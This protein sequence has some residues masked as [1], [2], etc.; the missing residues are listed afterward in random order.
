MAECNVGI[1]MAD[2]HDQI[3]ALLGKLDRSMLVS[4][5]ID[6]LKPELS[7]GSALLVEFAE[8]TGE[9]HGGYFDPSDHPELEEK[10]TAF[11]LK[12]TSELI[13]DEIENLAFDLEL[14]GDRVIAWRSIAHSPDWPQERMRDGH[15][16]ICWT[17]NEAH[18]IAHEGSLL[19]DDWVEIRLKALV[20]VE[21]VNWAET[22][23]LNAI[24]Y[25]TVGEESELRLNED[26]WVDLILVENLETDRVL[27]DFSKSP[28]TL[29]AGDR[30]TLS[31]SL[32]MGG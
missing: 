24:D 17:F 31:L 20:N 9:G 6:G 32:A 21:A 8:V 13:D 15:L 12:K 22:V 10:L 7:Y 18:A 4:E 16:G 2:T 5:A 25:F 19:H 28:E 3:A 1:T 11:V 14:D 30:S 29:P 27:A 23:I 26:A